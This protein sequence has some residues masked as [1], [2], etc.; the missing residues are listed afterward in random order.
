MNNKGLIKKGNKL[1]SI[2]NNKCPNCHEG[3]FYVDKNPFHLKKILTIHEK[4]S[5]CNLK[6]MLEPSFYHGAMYVSYGL[7]IFTSIITFLISI[8][9]IKLSLFTSFIVVIAA[10]IGLTPVMLKLSR[11]IYINLFVGFGEKNSTDLKP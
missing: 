1:Y 8:L 7:S 6:Y 4:C 2:L 10:L 3:D 5:S 9:I 11:I